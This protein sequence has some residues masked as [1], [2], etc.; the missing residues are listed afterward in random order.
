MDFKIAETF[1]SHNSI[2]N[3]LHALYKPITFL[4]WLTVSNLCEYHFRS[5]PTIW[6]DRG[7]ILKFQMPCR[8][9]NSRLSLSAGYKTFSTEQEINV[10]ANNNK[11]TKADGPTM[12]NISFHLICEYVFLYE[13]CDKDHIFSHFSIIIYICKT[14]L[15]DRC[16]NHIIYSSTLYK[17]GRY[18][19][20]RSYFLN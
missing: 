6:S 19:V 15:R 1:S 16:L 5:N 18:I 11:N 9:R 10:T 20:V 2:L 14:G 12:L 8:V 7:D 4:R 13:N 3:L 17:V